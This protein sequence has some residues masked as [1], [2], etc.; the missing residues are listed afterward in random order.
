MFL[1]NYRNW[2]YKHM[3]FSECKNVKKINIFSYSNFLITIKITLEK[4]ETKLQIDMS[5]LKQWKNKKGAVTIIST[6][7]YFEC[8][9]YVSA[10]TVFQ[11]KSE[12]A[13][14]KK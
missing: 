10:F 13:F 12:N 4:N 3:S 2:H 9:N 1:P 8:K 5:F 6:L 14:L 11:K 7:K